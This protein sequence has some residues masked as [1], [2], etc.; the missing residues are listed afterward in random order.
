MLAC[1]ADR[2]VMAGGSGRVGVP[3]LLV[4]VPF[5][6]APLE[7]LR[8]AIP[9]RHFAE[10][11]YGGATFEP[12]AALERGLVDEVVSG[13]ELTDVSVK[14]ADRLAG[15]NP[16]A[17]RLTKAQ[18]RRPTLDRIQRGSE[19]FDAEIAEVWLSDETMGL[20]R[21]YVAKTFKREATNNA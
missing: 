16:T 20:I 11:V 6:S 5:P 1:M 15:P 4:G 9:V 2:R 19:Q 18:V 3:E 10:I 21:A 7:V 13:A 14:W 8:F 17:F 12:T